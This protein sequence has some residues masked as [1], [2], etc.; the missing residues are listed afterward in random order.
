MNKKRQ[1]LVLSTQ[2]VTENYMYIHQFSVERLGR[3]STK[4]YHNDIL[5]EEPKFLYKFYNKTNFSINSLLEN[6]L[7]FSNP[8][9]FNDPFDCL[10]NREKYILKGSPAIVKHREDIGVCSFTVINDNPLM[11][12]HYTNSYNGFCLKFNNKNLLRNENIEIRSHVSYLENYNPSNDNFRNVKNEIRKL[13]VEEEFKRNTLSVLAM[14]QEY[15]WKYCDWQY[16]KEYRAIAI[17]A[18]KFERKFKFKN[19]DILEIY[20]G[21]RMKISDPNYYNLLLYILRNEYPHIRI[22]EVKPHPLIVKLEFE[23]IS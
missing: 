19:E 6:Y 4:I 15:C 16:E 17:D 2:W 20:I 1:E 12:G 11:W 21:H 5:L 10:T 7:Y 22:I 8:R 23:E 9:N 13:D 14:L 3:Y 18:T